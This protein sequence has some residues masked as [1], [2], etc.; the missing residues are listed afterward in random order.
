MNQITTLTLKV[1]RGKVKNPKPVKDKIKRL[2]TTKSK[3]EWL[4]R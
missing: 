4:A 2:L 1:K 3:N